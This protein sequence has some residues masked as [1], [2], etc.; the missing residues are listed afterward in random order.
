MSRLEKMSILGIRSF[1]AEDSDK[2]VITFFSPL[3]LIL[4]PNGTGKTVR[5]PVSALSLF[6]HFHALLLLGPK[7]QWTYGINSASVFCR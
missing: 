5:T 4:G 3:T 7:A 1:G 6:L 2:Q